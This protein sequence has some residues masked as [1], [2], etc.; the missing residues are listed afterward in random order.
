MTPQRR[1]YERNRS[2]VIARSKQWRLT[3]RKLFNRRAEA[4][5]KVRDRIRRDAVNELK[6][7]PCTD[8]GFS[9]P[10]E[11]MQFDHVRGRK[12]FEI[13]DRAGHYRWATVLKEIIKCDLV[14]ANCHCI[15]TKERRK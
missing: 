2:A 3:H 10:V 13:G 12:R 4:L 14:C 5:R 15:R 8:C 6:D 1:Y 11:C 9:Y 7:N